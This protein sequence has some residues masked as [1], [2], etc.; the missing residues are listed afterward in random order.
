MPL[1]SKAQVRKWYALAEKGEIDEVQLREAIRAT[2]R[3]KDLPE[4]A[5]RKKRDR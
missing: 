5:K 1:K 3:W 4:H 2:P